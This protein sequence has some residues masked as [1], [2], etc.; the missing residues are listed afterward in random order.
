MGEVGGC[1][2]LMRGKTIVMG[3]RQKVVNGRRLAARIGPRLE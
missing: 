2:Q 1:L 3:R